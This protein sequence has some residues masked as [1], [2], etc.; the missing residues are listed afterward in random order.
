MASKFIASDIEPGWVSST[1]QNSIMF[2][3]ISVC[4][5][6]LVEYLTNFLEFLSDNLDITIQAEYNQQRHIDQLNIEKINENL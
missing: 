5:Y 4:L 3:L 1:M 6:F 2:F